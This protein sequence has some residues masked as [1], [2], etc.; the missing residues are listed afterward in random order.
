MP[1]PVIAN[2]YQVVLNWTNASAPRDAANTLHFLDQL[3]TQTIANLNTDIEASVGAIMWQAVTASARVNS[4]RITPLDGVTAGVTFSVAAAAKWTGGGGADAILQGAQVVSLKSAQRG[5][6]G[7]NRVFL[8]W[9]AEDRQVNGT[10]DSV[11]TA[12]VAGAWATFVSAMS[13]LDWQLVAV[14]AVHNEE[15]ALASLSVSSR[16]YTQRRRARR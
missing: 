14:S 1:L 5:P 7:R 13:A 10:I 9:V 8:P 3:G 6:R 16:L 12:N 4:M 2:T 11:V 15:N